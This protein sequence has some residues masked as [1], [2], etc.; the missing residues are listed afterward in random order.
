MNQSE[1]KANSCNRRQA[2]ENAC[3]RGTIGFG[4]TSYWLREWREFCQPITERSN[5]KPKEKRNYF[6]HSIENR[7]NNK[8]NILRGGL[9]SPDGGFQE[10]PVHV[11]VKDGFWYFV[12]FFSDEQ[13]S[14]PLFPALRSLSLS[15]NKISEVRT[16]NV[17]CFNYMVSWLFIVAILLS[18][19]ITQCEEEYFRRLFEGKRHGTCCLLFDHHRS[20]ATFLL[21]PKLGNNLLESQRF[22]DKRKKFEFYRPPRKNQ[23]QNARTLASLRCFAYRKEKCEWSCCLARLEEAANSWDSTDESILNDWAWIFDTQF[24]VKFDY[25]TRKKL[26]TYY[27][28]VL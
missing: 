16:F 20:R 19:S 14:K 10:G 24:C 22:V 28:P 2:R 18:K 4:F 26:S 8:N 3:E 6:R 25:W 1:F 11:T 5:A 27:L 9:Q 23:L 12:C 7:S 21:L 17:Y 13:G 15:K